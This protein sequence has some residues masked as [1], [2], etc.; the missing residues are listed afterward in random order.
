VLV[1]IVS[2]KLLFAQK[3]LVQEFW[4]Y[5]KRVFLARSSSAGK[6][7]NANG[8]IYEVLMRGASFALIFL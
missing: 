4:L 2:K 6:L 5:Q 7:S 3:T 1:S 8:V